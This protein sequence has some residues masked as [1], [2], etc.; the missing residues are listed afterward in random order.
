MAT[1]LSKPIIILKL[2]I[3]ICIYMKKNSNVSTV[4]S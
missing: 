4:K 3:K 2:H 1:L